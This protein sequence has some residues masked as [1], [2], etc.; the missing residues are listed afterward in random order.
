MSDPL[1]G[2]FFAALAS[3]SWAAGACFARLGM[4]EVGSRTGTFISLAAGFV[5]ISMVAWVMDSQALFAVTWSSILWFALLGLIQFPGGR[6]LNY[7]GIRLAGVARTTSISGTSPLF[8]ALLAILFLGEQV[9][10]SILLGTVAVA[11]GLALV[12][13]QRGPFLQRRPRRCRAS[14]LGLWPWDFFVRWPGRLPME[15]AMPLLTRRH[16]CSPG[17]GNGHL[18]PLFWNAVSLC[19]LAAPPGQRSASTPMVPDHDGHGGNLL[20]LRHLLDVHRVGQGTGDV[21]FTD[22]GDLSFDRHDL[23]PSF[24][25]AIGTS[26]P[27]YGSGGHPGCGRDYLCRPGPG[28]LARIMHKSLKKGLI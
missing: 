16:P 3:T 6:F 2:A 15:P 11:V 10:S 12:M 13:S 26:D 5:A 1:A 9:T 7:T 24:F 17:P 19:H 8:A 20:L 27:S 21:G 25:T 28:E 4:Q 23:Y 18:H 22:R 14:D